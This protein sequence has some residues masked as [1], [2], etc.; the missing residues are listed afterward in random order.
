MNTLATDQVTIR[1]ST[2][3]DLPA[4]R[5]LAAIDS[6]AVPSGQLLLAEVNG[7]LVAALAV[8]DGRVIADPFVLT[9]AIVGLLR[10]HGRRPVHAG[11]RS[12]LRRRSLA[13]RTGR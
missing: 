8:A 12:G 3:G 6:A 1:S 5:R 11:R 4:I 2:S 13:G 10:D 9:S 7:D